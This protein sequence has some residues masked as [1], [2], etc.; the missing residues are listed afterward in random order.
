[1]VL[2]EMGLGA[3]ERFSYCSPLITIAPSRLAL[4]G[5]VHCGIEVMGLESQMN[6]SNWVKHRIPSFGKL[7]RLPI[8][9]HEKLCI[10]H[11]QRLEKEMTDAN[12]LWRKATIN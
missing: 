4:P 3:E 12:L 1:M 9:C 5:E 2:S 11:L 7:V 6:I 8:S 10:A